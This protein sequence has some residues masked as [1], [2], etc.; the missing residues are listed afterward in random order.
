VVNNI[1]PGDY[2]L[3]FEEASS[4][5]CSNTFEFRIL[6]PT[7]V[8]LNLVDLNNPNCNAD[9]QVTVLASG[10]TGPY[11]YAFVPDGSAPAG[12]FAAANYVELDP[13][14]TMDW[15]VYAMDSSFCIT[16]PLDITLVP[17]PEPVIAAVTSNQCTAAEGG[18]EIEITLATAGMG[19]HFLSVDGG[20]FQ[21]ASLS[22]AGDIA[23]ISG[24]SSGTHTVEV[25]DAN[26]CGNLVS[27]EIYPP[28]SL[29]AQVLAQASC[30]L[31]DG[32]IE[33]TASGGSGSFTYELFLGAASVVGIQGSP[34]F[35]GLA[36]GT[37]T[38]FA[39]DALVPACQAT[40]T[41]TLEVPTPVS[42]STSVADVSCNGGADG[43]INVLLD[44]GM[45]N[46]P[47]SYQLFDAAGVVA[48]T[49]I[50]SN[51]LFD[52]L[53]AG[54][55]TVRVTS[56]RNCVTDALVTVG[57]PPVL[58]A[59]AFVTDFA[60]AADNSV[61]QASIVLTATGGTA[62]YLYSLDGVTFS[63]SNTFAVSDTG[64]PQNFT[65]VVRDANGCIIS[66]PVA[67]SP[68]PEI[69][70]AVVA[71][72]VAISCTNP[73]EV[74]ITVTGGSGDFDFDLL[75]IGT[76]ATQ[77]PGAGVF[78]ADFTL[79]SP[80]DYTFRVTDNITGCTFTTAPYNIAPYDLI[81]VV[82]TAVTPVNCFGD[83]SGALEVQVTNYTGN[84][85][86][87]VF[88][89]SGA[90]VTPVTPG[91]TA[92]NPLTI[93]TLAAGNYRV[94]VVATDA[95]FCADDSNTVT[96]GSPASALALAVVSNTN[97]NCNSGAL[98]AVSASG[99]TPGY[100][101]A[102]MPS[103][104]VPAAGD[105]SSNP[106]AELA[107]AA[108]PATY[109]V[110]VRDA[111]L[112][113]TMIPVTVDEDPLPVLTVPALAADQ[114]ASDGTSYS[115]TVSGTGVGPLSYS[116]GSGFQASDT[117][118]VSAPGTYTV[119]L[120][121]GNGCLDTG[122]IVI[123]PP[124]DAGV[125]IAAQPSC[126]LNDGELTVVATG[127]SGSYAYD[128]L[129]G[130][131]VSI[132]SG[133]TQASNVFSGLA[134]DT[135]TAVVFDAS[136]TSCTAQ[137][138]VTLA[139][140]TPVTLDPAAVADV[141][142]S[143]GSDGSIRVNLQPAGPGINDNPPYV[144]TLYDGVGNLLAGPQSDPLFSGLVAGD[145]RIEAV[146]G[147]NCA[148]TQNVTVSEPTPLTVT[149]VATAFS[150]AADNSVNT[151]VITVSVPSGSGTSP[152]LYS[153][154]GINYQASNLFEVTDNGLVQTPVVY[155][156]DANGCEATTSV[157]LDPLNTF[158]AGVS[159]NL[160]ITC[161]SPEEVLVSVTDNGNPANTYTFE[162]LPVGNPDG[163]LTGTPSNTTATFE[164]SAPGSYT[165]R[166]TD[167]AT[168]CFVITDPYEIAP[169]D[170][171]SLTATPVAPVVCFGDANGA[172][173]LEIA[174]YTGN[175]TYE[176]FDA[177]GVST[178]IGG[179]GSTAVNP[180]T[181]TGLS[182]GNYFLRVTELDPPFCVEDSA[183]FTIVSPDR[184]LTATISE[185]ANVT[186]TNDLGEILVVPDG[187]YAPYD[188]AL[189]NT[190]TGQNYTIADVN[191]YLFTG[192][193]AGSFTVE[194]TDSAGCVFNGSILLTEPLP[195]SAGITATPTTLACY[196]DENATVTAINVTGGEGSYSYQ[197]NVY[198]ATGSTVLFTSGTQPNPVFTGLGSGVYSITVTDGWECGI[199]TAQVVISEPTEVSS[200][201]VQ[202][203]Q[204]TCTGDAGLILTASGGTA[205]YEYSVDGINFLPMAGGDTHTFS[206]TAGTY[207]YYVRDVNGC[208]AGISN[209]VS[210][211][212]VAPMALDIDESAAVINCT[213][214]TT[215]SLTAVAT[216]GL[217]NYQYE[218]Y[219]DSALTVL[220]A[221]P[222]ANGAFSGLGQGSY[223]VRSTSLD[224]EVV[225][226]EILISEPAPLQV[227][228]EEFTNVTCAG[229]ADGTI[230]V[231][232]SGGT[233]TILY[234][235]SPNLNQFDTENIFTGLSAGVYDVIAQDENG[236]FIPF[237]FTIT[238]PEPIV[239]SETV[240][241]EVC[242]GSEDGAV[243]ITITG[244]T[245]PYSAAFNSNNPA[246]YVPGQT[247]FTGLAAGTY[248]IFVRDSQ[249]CEANIIVEVETGVNLNAEVTP[250]YE[251]TG[252]IPDNRLEVLLE[253]PSVANEVMYALD[254]TDPADMQLDPDFTNIPAGAHYLA[255]SHTNGCVVT[256]DFEIA[257]Y[258]PLELVLE[259]RNINEITAIASGG[260]PDYTFYFNDV[261]NGTDNTFYI[262]ESGTYTV[263]VIDQNGC[264]AEA[265][266][267]MEF[268]DIEIPNFFTPDGDGMND[269]WIP[270]NM[271]GFPQILIKI[272]DRYGR[273]VDEIS[274]NVRGWDGTYDGRELPTGD[275]WYVIKLNGENDTRE[276]VGHFT[277]YR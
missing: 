76:V 163:V 241:A 40:T 17:D 50:Q 275:Y 155:V 187:G 58:A 240:L 252:N 117:F 195:I 61:S 235:I 121:D 84:Y 146:S 251:C 47:Y 150:C 72:L 234:A 14:I 33:L 8:V 194:I 27:V 166:V 255:I 83:A 100:E 46:P 45:D 55:Y 242:S 237:Q 225:S 180:A 131:G 80:G 70:D 78:T 223:W 103:G 177:T 160:A 254:S 138:V 110:F 142:C 226:D 172:V 259:Q 116:V 32:Q 266:I 247:S 26:G 158:T 29:S 179:N 77:S 253:D 186:C 152:Y 214:E 159:Q 9:G 74:R 71:P 202:S 89:G 95:P 243:E 22:V 212:P 122:S 219:G 125:L 145:Y 38:A 56:G 238:A 6:E 206:V 134:P 68:L 87:Q 4:P 52:S 41:V 66:V 268:I 196:G 144:F 267:F 151:A 269:F 207:Q 228:R 7:P 88:D 49:P 21:P 86:Y 274:Y 157:T 92:V 149:A 37:Y 97:A 230:A 136:G 181:I 115:F 99:G 141:T 276:F 54:D 128:L 244:G 107:P 139:T 18:F 173:S 85:T 200:A 183:I 79:T 135:Y 44:A 277:L 262:T 224:C 106:G 119:T 48:I 222:Q 75:P 57:Q 67:L 209:Q 16:G 23:L 162:L 13:S 169:F 246:D 271:E 53:A 65:S 34:L 270:E 102:F 39:Y 249:G 111:N 114:C 232:V 165:F 2:V 35:T 257:A 205:P 192:L 211:E 193:S 215:A 51:P 69:V 60:C 19:P 264:V 112:C 90:A 236:C 5:F 156:R 137:A 11:T 220:L 182:G 91:S 265:Q 62:P 105:Y 130:S 164:L 25:R 221:G 31:N 231:E 175:Y 101:Y 133:A 82:A 188:I 185:A 245:A 127:G 201:L 272:Y 15:D 198:D 176:V 120:R 208:E 28:A 210:I 250:V 261:D 10:G 216:G 30:A 64:L 42:F 24:L 263:R 126:A 189:A 20:A 43:S 217:G 147:L 109:D 36:P 190:T 227:D 154:D 93:S 123:L 258:Q 168:G 233:G 178:G 108:Y 73:E 197:L 98:V 59:S 129:D 94:Q 153:I 273:V 199:E 104:S 239:L 81:E 113:V 260:V 161:T 248:V 184:A 218:L 96:I 143:G 204:L 229:E 213:G 3:F 132:T 1:P 12:N 118:T 256:I 124:L 171:I 148:A 203:A 174:S 140:P 191:A 63:D 170:L 167:N